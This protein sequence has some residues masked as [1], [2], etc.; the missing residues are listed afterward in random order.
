MKTFINRNPASV[1]H[2]VSIAR[3]AVGGGRSVAFAGGGTDLLQ[4]VKDRIRITSYNVCYTKLLRA[5][6]P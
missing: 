3:D 2:A 5:V 1:G 6:S 4:L